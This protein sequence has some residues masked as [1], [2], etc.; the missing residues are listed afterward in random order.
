VSSARSSRGIGTLQAECDG[1][2][3]LEI[4]EKFQIELQGPPD[5]SV[6][7]LFQDLDGVHCLPPTPREPD[8]RLDLE[9]RFALPNPGEHFYAKPPT[10]KHTLLAVLKKGEWG[11][12]LYQHL[13]SA[14]LL[15]RAAF[16]MTTL[17]QASDTSDWKVLKKEFC[18]L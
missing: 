15:S 14:A 8:C 11:Q 13:Q 16:H 3:C 4:G 17:L 9:G 10:G 1:L 5:W 18:V 12:P 7:V 6:I 2:E